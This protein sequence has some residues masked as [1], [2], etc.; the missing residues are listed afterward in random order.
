MAYDQ[1]RTLCAGAQGHCREWLT[2]T[3][4]PKE[5]AAAPSEKDAAL[6]NNRDSGSVLTWLNAL[7]VDH[8]IFRLVWSNLSEVIPE[9]LY[10]SNHPTPARLV[11]LTKRYGLKTLINLRGRQSK[12]GADTLSR[13][14]AARLG[15]DFI[16]VSLKGRDAPDPDMIL[17]LHDLYTSMRTPALMHCK[18][19]ADRTGFAA[20]LC[21]L[22]QGGTTE[23]AARQLSIRFGHIRQARAGVLDEFFRLYARDGEGRKPFL[24]WVREDYDRDALR[25][26]F[27]ASRLANF[28]NDRVLSRE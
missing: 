28:I 19:G 1:E 16:D 21:V 24:D 13:D 10:R 15:L 17:H 23:A 26:D 7:L 14:M 9:R 20:G 25:R 5:A 22:F 4:H 18:S 6:Q 11:T 2:R 12:N 3:N 27:R 8:A